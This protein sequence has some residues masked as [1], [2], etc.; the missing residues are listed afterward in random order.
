MKWEKGDQVRIR[1]KHFIGVQIHPGARRGI[2]R[3]HGEF[4]DGRDGGLKGSSIV[5]GKGANIAG[6]KDSHKKME[7]ATINKFVKESREQKRVDGSTGGGD[8]DGQRSGI[9]KD[10]VESDLSVKEVKGPKV[11]SG[12]RRAV[13]S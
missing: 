11:T 1:G 5:S 12:G 10:R 3:R 9:W 4:F 13:G 6:P 7:L 8:G 2:A